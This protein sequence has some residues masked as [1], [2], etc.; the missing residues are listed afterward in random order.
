VTDQEYNR[1]K[2]EY[3]GYEHYNSSLDDVKD[4]PVTVTQYQGMQGNPFGHAGISVGGRPP[5]GYTDRSESYNRRAAMLLPVPGAVKPIG[6]PQLNHPLSRATMAVTPEQAD[7]IQQYINL[8][9]NN[10]GEY[11]LLSNNCTE[12]ACSALQ[13][14]GVPANIGLL[15]ND[16]VLELLEIQAYGVPEPPMAP[17][18]P[19]PFP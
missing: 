17:A 6:T 13:A 5:V 19:T 8:R 18:P 11:Q 4:V 2:K 1:A 10:P 3:E 12:F 15:P 9:T 16:L 14:G 7:A